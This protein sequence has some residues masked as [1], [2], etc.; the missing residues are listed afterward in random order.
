MF[1]VPNA[2]RIKRSD[3]FHTDNSP[4][5][6]EADSRSRSASPADIDT[7]HD[8]GDATITVPDYGFEYDFISP[9]VAA[10][11][12]KSEAVPTTSKK[13]EV[14]DNQTH[15]DDQEQEQEFQFRLFTSATVTA[16]TQ[17]PSQSSQQ[18]SSNVA[19]PTIR[20]SRTPSPAPLSGQDGLL[21]LDK[22]HFVRPHRPE[23]YYFTAAL[24]ADTAQAL[25]SQYAEVA[26]S[27]SHVLSRSK[28]T[29]WPGSVLPWRV[30]HVELVAPNRRGQG[31]VTKSTA[32]KVSGPGL[33]SR[34]TS[35]PK[36][37]KK[38]RI[39]LRQRLA[40][41]AEM[42]AQAVAAELT[43]KE[44]RTRRNR[45]KKVKRKEREKMKK[46]KLLQQ[47]EGTGAQRGDG[48]GDGGD[49]GLHGETDQGEDR[50]SEAGDVQTG[51]G[52]PTIVA[53]DTV[54]PKAEKTDPHQ[55]HTASTSARAPT[56]T[57]ITSSKADHDT[58]QV[59]SRPAPTAMRTTSASAPTRRAPIERGTAPTS[60][61]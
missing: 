50:G 44:K 6:S 48:D 33:A 20:L 28:S 35:R 61:H 53:D 36:P 1:E 60:V 21:S 19:R 32:G 39:V 24:P 15:E 43:E 58:E 47:E 31:T 8:D 51:A 13:T 41:R 37:S 10:I 38:R 55:L 23:T 3:L 2:K 4:T 56:A 16:Q 27:T 22:A 52:R 7:D 5:G 45:E 30:I 26:V 17:K 57:A 54:A 49:D 14:H 12:P 18:Q 9:T 11:P 25:K 40:K 46:Q 34:S 42:A 29:I 59:L